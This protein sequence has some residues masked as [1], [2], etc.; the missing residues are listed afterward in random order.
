MKI[1]IKSWYTG[2]V[3]FS[4]ETETLKLALEAAVKSRA[5]LTGA[6]LTGANLRGADLTRANL[7][8][9]DLT[10][11]NLRGANLR[12]AD[13]RGADLRDA[14]L[15]GADLRDADLRGADLRDANLRG[16]DLRG[17][18]LRDANLRDANLTGADLTG[19]N[20]RGADLTRANLRDANLRV[21]RDDLW[22][23]LSSAPTEVE[24]LRAALLAGTVDGSTYEG[25]CACLVGTIAK[26]RH[27]KYTE[28]PNLRPDS[29]RPAERFFMGISRG[30]TP[31]TSTAAKLAVQWI[32]EW[33]T[34]MKAAFAGQR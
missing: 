24:G 7:T 17:A 10:G 25:D 9:A 32:D 12:D 28:V 20:L 22:A 21:V 8:G 4:L 29:S 31:E 3:L 6:D 16:A 5:N 13:L 19:A 27:C 30:D 15:R 18:N 14:N 11:A 23:V 2:G 34:N 1:E 33:L 26:V